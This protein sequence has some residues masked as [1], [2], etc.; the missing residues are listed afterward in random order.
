MPLAFVVLWSTGFLAG[1]TGVQDSG[2]LHFLF[3][4]FLIVAVLLGLTAL[5]TRAPWPRSPRETLHIIVAGLLVH[6]SYLGGVFTALHAGIS[7][8]QIAMIVGLQP[9]LTAILAARLLKERISA[10][11]WLGLLI[12]LIGISIVIYPKLPHDHSLPGIDSGLPAAL[13]ALLAITLGTIYQKRFCA[14]MDLRSGGTLQYLACALVLPLFFDA[15]DP[16]PH[17]SLSFILSL[18]WLVLVLSVGAIGLLYRLLA[19]G[20]ASQVAS[21]FYLVPPTTVLFGVVLLGEPLTLITVLGA[22][23][24]TVG[25]A[26]ANA[27]D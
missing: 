23:F 19:R 24:V 2:P 25:V 18:S 15:S 27:N 16:A 20:A 22:L 17:W 10:R 9:I 13:F 14:N 8:G 1:K 12:G 7:A 11:R 3:V 26:L 6:A 4:R 21:Y 5:A